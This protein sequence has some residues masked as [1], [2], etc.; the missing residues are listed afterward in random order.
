MSNRKSGENPD[1]RKPKVSSAMPINRGLGG[2]KGKAKAVPD[3]QPVN[4]PAL[5]LNKPKMTKS[6][7]LGG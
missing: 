7:T 1:H 3:G 4:I 2:P 6:S 5:S